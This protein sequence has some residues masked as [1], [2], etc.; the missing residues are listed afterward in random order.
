MDIYIK[1]LMTFI[2]IAAMMIFVYS[3]FS[4]HLADAHKQIAILAVSVGFTNYYF[5]FVIDSPYSFVAQTAIWIV[6]MIILRKYSFLF[7]LIFCGVGTIFVAIVDGA[8]TYAVIALNISTMDKMISNPLHYTILH[9]AVTSM[10]LLIAYVLKK[11]RIGF[12]FLRLGYSGKTL[13][14][15]HNF[16]LAAAL[17]LVVSLFQIYANSFTTSSIDFYLIISMTL[18][19]IYVLY[20]A[21]IKNRSDYNSRFVG[22]GSGNNKIIKSNKPSKHNIK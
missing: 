18:V 17:I 6:M 19:I 3:I 22:E 2:T 10:Y 11:F 8:T 5:K 7:S 1:L 14:K 15:P 9:L 4:L 16:I 12:V 13:L 20:R 21:F